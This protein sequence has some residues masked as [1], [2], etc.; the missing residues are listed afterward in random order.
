MKTYEI[1]YY[2]TENLSPD[3]QNAMRSNQR[4]IWLVGESVEA[5]SPRKA[6]IAAKRIYSDQKVRIATR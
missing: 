5:D 2:K 6:I 3:E 1:D 4:G